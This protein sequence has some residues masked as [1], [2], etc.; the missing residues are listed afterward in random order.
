[1]N[2]SLSSSDALAGAEAAAASPPSP[3]AGGSSSTATTS[4][5]THG[6]AVVDGS[7]EALP[8]FTPQLSTPL[9]PLGLPGVSAGIATGAVASPPVVGNF[10]AEYAAVF[11]PR[12]HRFET[13]NFRTPAS[14]AN[15]AAGVVP[16]AAGDARRVGLL[17]TGLAVALGLSAGVL[18]FGV[19]QGVRGGYAIVY[20][21]TAAVLHGGSGAVGVA[22]AG[23]T[24]AGA[25][26]FM[27][28][29]VAAVA[30]A[31]ALVVYVAPL[32]SGSGI[33]E[34]KS[35]LNGVR[36]PGFLRART[37][38]VKAAG[39][40]A[41]ISGG[42]VIGKQ[43]PIIHAVAVLAA[44]LS[45][46][47]SGAL[48][49]RLRG[50][51][52]ARV[53]APLR[54]EGWKRDFTTIGAAAG[55]AVAFGAPL[56]GWVWVYEDAVTHWSW[57][58]GLLA[59]TAS[60]VGGGLIG[61]LNRLARGVTG[62][63][64]SASLVGVGKL[65]VAGGPA[66]VGGATGYPLMDFP[67]FA[68][69]GVAGGLYGAAL[70]A[71]SRRLTLFRFR[72]ISR[73]AARLAE[74]AGMAL[75]TA[76]VRFTLTAAGGSCVPVGGP[77][78]AVDVAA[79][80]A[81]SELDFSRWACGPGTANS[82]AAL[83][84]SP[85]DVVART[86]LY[87]PG[88]DTLGAAPLG[89][90]AAFFSV[91]AIVTY[92]MAIPSGIFFPGVVIGAAVGRL[93]GVGVNAVW[94]SRPAGA[95]VVVE[96]YALIGVVAMLAGIT[97][98][99]SVV[100]VVLEATGAFTASY[101]AAVAALI[102]KAVSDAL[103]PDGIYDTHIKLKG[104]PWLPACPPRPHTYERVLVNDLMV[105]RVVGVRRRVPVGDIVALLRRST[106]NAFPVFL[107]LAAPSA[108]GA[109]EG[110]GDG[111]APGEGEGGGGEASAVGTPSAAV[112]LPAAAGFREASQ[113]P[114]SPAGP[115]KVLS[116]SVGYD[117]PTSRSQGGSF[118]TSG[119]SLRAG[120]ARSPSA[121]SL[122]PTPPPP[123]SSTV[124]S[125][126]LAQRPGIP[127][128]SDSDSGSDGDNGGGSDEGG[129]VRDP[130]RHAAGLHTS[131]NSA[132]GRPP[133]P[134]GGGHPARRPRR[135]ES[136]G[137]RRRSRSDQPPSPPTAAPPATRASVDNQADA[138]YPFRRSPGAAP[139][140][141]VVSL[142]LSVTVD[143]VEDATAGPYGRAWDF[144][145][146]T[147]T[148]SGGGPAG[149]AADRRFT[150]HLEG[151]VERPTL[152]GLVRAAAQSAEG[153]GVPL[154]SDAAATAT[155][156]ATATVA[157]AAIAA[158]VGGSTGASSPPPALPSPLP[159]GPSVGTASAAE[160]AAASTDALPP[161]ATDAAWPPP[162]SLPAEAALIAGL[163]AA[164][165][166][167]FVDL[168][169]YVDVNPLLLS[170]TATAREAYTLLRGTGARHVL[171]M[172]LAGGTVAGVLTRKDV[173]PEAVEEALGE[174]YGSRE[175]RA[176]GDKGESAV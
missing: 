15:R 138:L 108:A 48:G 33:P 136:T 70:P 104:M 26:V 130:A 132:S 137:S 72:Y 151:M 174:G 152:V 116:G 57:T 92:G 47:A 54:T 148:P 58:V 11:A 32:G 98:T 122:T 66:L 172:D 28:L 94:T 96:A 51:R 128:T 24:A 65:T 63:L 68:L 17:A 156:T 84:Y 82:W 126:S 20:R 87:A 62:G 99:V 145:L 34:L 115:I 18:A 73:P 121:P 134:R 42:L 164:A 176:G 103:V 29:N 39:V 117:Q 59:L 124:V 43:G 46:G 109:A 150:Y 168:A 79:A 146:F 163:P 1:M 129:H 71:V 13:V 170:H 114:T 55:V 157:V 102:S 88:A 175:G 107:K 91:F 41:A 140:A 141:A 44:G 100:I 36:V 93:L 135:Q 31:S 60:L 119:L 69:L 49:A 131:L 8:P 30:V 106:H 83:L 2:E 52:A 76:A 9:K 159:T 16:L 85:S 14:A 64:V 105:R 74:A 118:V 95:P 167:T 23:R 10:D 112:P 53:L 67:F 86:L 27:A 75:L 139:T 80:V 173:L 7:R 77:G 127:P 90:A 123:P 143:V 37:L 133:R 161:E 169:P 154:A 81:S 110:G 35:Y 142:P 6:Q 56:G 97:R 89:V 155:A 61:V 4:T 78:G 12:Q 166:D 40:V 22:S 120:H 50:A 45:Q 19:D 101:A 25:V 3:S 153:G 160:S 158:A 38:A 21:V 5:G 144:V 147:R 113:L 171:A 165:L 149:A 162:A 125:P 111:G